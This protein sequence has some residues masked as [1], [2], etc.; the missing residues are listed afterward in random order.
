MLE[1]LVASL[2]NSMVYPYPGDKYLGEVSSTDLISGSELASLVG[3]SNGIVKDDTAGWLQFKSQEGV[4]FLVAKKTLRYRLS[5]NQLEAA[6][7]VY[8]NKQV[9]IKDKL[10]KLRLLKGAEADPSAWTADLGQD[11]PA[12]VRSSEWN[13]FIERVA[14][15]NPIDAPN[16]ANFSLTD[17][18]IAVTSTG[19]L[20]L[21]METLGSNSAQNVARGNASLPQF[22]YVNKSDGTTSTQDHYGWRPVLELIGP[23]KLYPNSGPGPQWLQAGDEQLGY[24][25]EVAAVDMIT[26]AALKS[27]LGHSAGSL[28]ADQGY[29]KFFY[30]GKILF[31][32]KN[33]YCTSLSWNQ[34][35]AAGGIYG[36]KDTGKYPAATPVYQ[37]KPLSWSGNGK[38]FSMIP[39]SLTVAPDPYVA[40]QDVSTGNE[41]SDLLCR[42]FASGL[43]GSGEW[44][45]F[46]AAALTMNSVQMGLSTL[47]ADNN[48]AGLRGYP[49]GNSYTS[50]SSL[51]KDDGTGYSQH[52]RMV[53]ELEG[54]PTASPPEAGPAF[55]LDP[56]DQSAGSTTIVD[57]SFRKVPVTNSGVVVSNDG[58]TAGVK[59]M[60][61]DKSAVK[62]LRMSGTLMPNALA[63]DFQIDFWFKP[64]G[65]PSGK[66]V[67]VSQ[68][69]QS[70]NNGGLM[71]QVNTDGADLFFFAPQSTS[72]ALITAPV[73]SNHLNWVK[74]S[75]RRKGNT[76]EYW[77]DGVLVASAT[78]TQVATKTVDWIVGSWM[79]SSNVVP[80][81]GVVPLGGWLADFRVYDFYKG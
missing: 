43:P 8:G 2:K 79:N 57:K 66:E 73:N 49:S 25:G 47:G 52:F 14:A 71:A 56:S 10:Y 41:Y 31:I 54:D 62:Y 16:F 50:L 7:L 42:L 40:A 76:F 19:R 15:E 44:G 26:N 77:Q 51:T 81:T 70:A 17:L 27:H 53:L 6:L 12:L 59:S 68:W 29:L 4:E 1:L 60:F 35:Y 21:C 46:T 28:R 32:G 64:D 38:L 39:R 23:A 34:L 30:K 22:N 72:T 33:T 9:V 20:T 13:R 45:R 24:F 36:T 74:R 75:L 80:G 67:I 61:F 58:P 65:T 48:K 3:F 69:A 5:W 78:S 37:Y 63:R 55:W 11:N 18:S